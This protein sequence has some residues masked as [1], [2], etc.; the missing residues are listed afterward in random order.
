M[1]ES[2]SHPKG[3]RQ[4][5][6]IDGNAQAGSRAS[7]SHAGR[8][9]SLPIADLQ[10]FLCVSSVAMV[11]RNTAILSSLLISF[12]TCNKIPLQG[13]N[14][15]RFRL[16]ICCKNQRQVYTALYTERVQ[17]SSYVSLGS[18]HTMLLPL[19]AS[20]TSGAFQSSVPRLIVVWRS[21][22]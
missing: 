3:L 8:H 10:S 14:E 11:T 19:Y 15:V 13:C 16:N 6:C 22:S 12:T 20:L 17:E 1:R 4:F 7:C 21:V 18:Y 9:V 2:R 5:S